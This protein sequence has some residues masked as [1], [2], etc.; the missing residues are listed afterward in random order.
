MDVTDLGG[1]EPPLPESTSSKAGL[2]DEKKW[3]HTLFR[4]TE[5]K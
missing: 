5:I 3:Y 1:I 4:D 2:V